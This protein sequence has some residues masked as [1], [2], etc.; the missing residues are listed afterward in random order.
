MGV[1]HDEHSEQGVKIASVNAQ[2]QP[3][4]EPV[5]EESMGEATGARQA[6]ANSRAD[7]LL[8]WSNL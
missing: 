1:I 6:A 4:T 7:S 3:D 5:N 2:A 8:D